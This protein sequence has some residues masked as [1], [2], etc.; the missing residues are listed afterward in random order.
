MLHLDAWVRSLVAIL[1]LAGIAELLLPTGA[2]KGYARALLGLLVL[3]GMLQPLVGLLHGE[4]RL[5]LPGLSGPGTVAVAAET[6][7]A[8]E[9]GLAAYEQLVAAQAAKI[10]EQVPGVQSASATVS[11]A[12]GGDGSPAVQRAA[13]NVQPTAAGLAQGAG[14]QARV[15]QAVAGGLGVVT[16]AVDVQV[17]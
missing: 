7:S 16:D 6:S 13:V 2:M 15:R 10:A 8:A 3:L 1:L 14:L 11:F 17:W 5:E 4:I 12:A 9:S